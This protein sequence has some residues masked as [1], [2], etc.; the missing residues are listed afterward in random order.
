MSVEGLAESDAII[1]VSPIALV[2]V[3]I[4]EALHRARP[5]WSERAIE[6]ATTYLY[7]RMS[8]DE[9]RALYEAYAARVIIMRSATDSE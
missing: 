2:P 3:I 1:T 4:H 9:C 7:G 8:D 6:Q 5:E